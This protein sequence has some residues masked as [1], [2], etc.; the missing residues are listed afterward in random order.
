M[1]QSPVHK[2]DSFYGL[3]TQR[4]QTFVD[5]FECSMLCSISHP[6][7]PRFCG[8]LDNNSDQLTEK[9]QSNLMELFRL[10]ISIF[11]TV[12]ALR[13][14]TFRCTCFCFHSFYHFLFQILRREKRSNPTFKPNK[15][16]QSSQPI[17]TLM[18]QTPT[19]H[20]L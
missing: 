5:F 7:R 4:K 11:L 8:H 17:R 19:P 16:T 1:I 3:F 6:P 18:A 2:T 12:V 9:N 15:S 10:L 20:S 13:G 14:T